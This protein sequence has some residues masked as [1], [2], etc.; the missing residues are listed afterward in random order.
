[1]CLSKV[2]EKKIS[3]ICHLCF[4]FSLQFDRQNMR[5]QNCISL[6]LVYSRSIASCQSTI[7]RWTIRLSSARRVECIYFSYLKWWRRQCDC[8]HNVFA[9]VHWHSY[10]IILIAIG[11]TRVHI[12]THKPNTIVLFLISFENIFCWCFRKCRLFSCIFSLP[13]EAIEIG[14]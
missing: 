3:R 14:K 12:L 5:S 10:D 11:N 1:M 8:I 13:M 9:S 4:T 7:D 6:G 2:A